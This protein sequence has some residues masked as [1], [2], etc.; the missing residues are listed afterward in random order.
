MKKYYFVCFSQKTVINT[1]KK[2]NIVIDYHP[3]TFMNELI[4]DYPADNS[5]I[6]FYSEITKEQYDALNG[7]L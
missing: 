1:E 3:M 4:N 7:G 6:H 5:L 2:S